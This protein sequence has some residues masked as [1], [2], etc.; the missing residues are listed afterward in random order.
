MSNSLEF[1]KIK[2]GN[3]TLSDVALELSSLKATIKNY[4]NKAEIVKAL[5]T[6]DVKTLRNISQYYYRTSGIYFRICNY[7]SQMYRYD[8]YIVDEIYDDKVDL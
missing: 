5:S 1:G 3:K 7:F 2:S 6:K 8:W 4:N